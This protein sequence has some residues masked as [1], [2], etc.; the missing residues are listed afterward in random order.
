MAQTISD[1]SLQNVQASNSGGAQ[2]FG[3]QPA[4]QNSQGNQG[5]SFNQQ[6]TSGG[7]GQQVDS[8][9]K[10][11][12]T[13]FTNVN[14]I[15]NANQGN[16]LGQTIQT[17]IQNNANNV[18]QNISNAQGSF[19]QGVQANTFGANDQTNVNNTVNTASQLQAG[20]TVDPTQLKQFQTY[21]AGGYQGPTAL[22]NADLLQGQAQQA[23]QLGQQVGTAG[24]QQNLLQRF[25]GNSQYGQGQKTLDQLLL[26]QQQG[27]LNQAQANTFGL[28]N[29]ALGA[30]ANAGQVANQAV[31]ANQAFGQNAIKAAQAAQTP[32]NT[33]ISNAVTSD[34]QNQN[35]LQSSYNNLQKLLGESASDY[36]KANPVDPNAPNASQSS[37]NP[38]VDQLNSIFSTLQNAGVDQNTIQQLAGPALQANI[39]NIPGYLNTL[40]NNISLNTQGGLTV[41]NPDTTGYGTSAYQVNPN[42][43]SSLANT[44]AVMNSQQAAQLNALS[45]LAGGTGNIN[46]AGVGTYN[47]NAVNVNLAN[48][49]PQ[50][51]DIASSGETG[52]APKMNNGSLIQQLGGGLTNLA[53]AVPG[54]VSPVAKDVIQGYGGNLTNAANQLS[55]GNVVGAAG[56]VA[57][58]PITVGTNLIS[59]LASNPLGS[60]V[61]NPISIASN[62]ASQISNPI[63]SVFGGGGGGKIICTELHRQGYISD[64]V[65][66][67]DAEFGKKYRKFHMEAYEGYLIIAIPIVGLMKRNSLFTK[68]I[69]IVVKPWSSYMANSMDNSIQGSKLGYVINKIGILILPF[70]YKISKLIKRV[71]YE[72]SSI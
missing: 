55:Q 5:I 19:N 63:A 66:K 29:Q 47:P 6:T 46:A 68:V 8:A 18:K 41:S 37:G 62:L 35:Q 17:G 14:N 44:N 30:N 16:Q 4:Q 26:G 56:T 28:N 23:E 51:S 31:A 58:T 39:N 22:Q 48:I 60:I 43:V 24:G 71:Q 25:V 7:Q 49:L 12:G 57:T 3:Q 67:L 69:S 15:L 32:I 52:S 54:D 21:T 13:G 59:Q 36:S 61:N 64:K 9:P 72:Y 70:V 2:A 1:P 10:P 38:A 11:K 42:D 40:M 33:N 20:Q 65:I 27:A 34:I 53:S 50:N 45:Q